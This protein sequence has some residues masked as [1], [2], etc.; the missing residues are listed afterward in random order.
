MKEYGNLVDW[1]GLVVV[2]YKIL[3]FFDNRYT[4]EK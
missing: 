2:R 1:D 4:I 3:L